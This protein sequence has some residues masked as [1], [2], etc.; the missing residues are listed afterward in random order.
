MPLL[1][2]RSQPEARSATTKVQDWARHLGIPVEVL[3][4]RVAVSETENPCDVMRVDEIVE[5]HTP[6]HWPSL[7]VAAE[8]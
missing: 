4:H 3:T 8:H 7:H 1:Y 5:E 6:S 2:L